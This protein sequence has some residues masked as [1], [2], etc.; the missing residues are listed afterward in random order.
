MLRLLSHFVSV[1]IVFALLMSL[2]LLINK[3]KNV[4]RYQIFYGKCGNKYQK[5]PTNF[6]IW[7]VSWLYKWLVE[8]YFFS[9]INSWQHLPKLYWYMA[10]EAI[11][12]Y[13]GGGRGGV[14][15]GNGLCVCVGGIRGVGEGDRR[16][17]TRMTFHE[18][19]P[20]GHFSLEK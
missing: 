7:T 14:G 11:K 15:S 13:G 8:N 5:I 20:F 2:H 3:R 17:F 19:I 1:Y 18:C 4:Y 12:Q 9:K 6:E 10:N 16:H